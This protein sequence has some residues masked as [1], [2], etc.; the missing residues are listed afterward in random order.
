MEYEDVLRHVVRWLSL[1]RALERVLSSWPAIKLYFIQQGEQETNKVIWSFVQDQDGELQ[2]DSKVR[3]SLPEC[4]QNFVHHFTNI[5]TQSV[6][7]LDRNR[8]KSS[9]IHDITYKLKD[10]LE[11][12]LRDNFFG[13]KVNSSLQ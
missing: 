13:S 9:E 5:T 10:K 4:Y 3:L 7:I 12:R 11:S 6:L 1:F 2:D 8:V